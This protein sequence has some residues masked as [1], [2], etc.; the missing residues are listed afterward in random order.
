LYE[1]ADMANKL[2]G[3]RSGEPVGMHLDKHFITCSDKLKI[4]F[5]WARDTQKILQENPEII[6][7]WFKLMEDTK[8]KYGV[9]DNNMHN[10]NKTGFQMGVIGS[11]K[12]VTGAERRAWPQLSQSGSCKWVKVI[13]SVC[14]T[15]YATL[16]FII[17][18]ERVH[19]SA[20]YNE[21]DIPRD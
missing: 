3:V 14:I 15:G 5:N 4:A 7:A 16:L 8:A 11:M 2:P 21:V 17:Y 19:I 20:W 13:Q 6:S 12:A 9:H 1:V 10:F 18:K